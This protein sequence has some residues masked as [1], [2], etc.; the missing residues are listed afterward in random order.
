[1]EERD[2]LLESAYNKSTSRVRC[3]DDYKLLCWSTE[4][5]QE[6][7]SEVKRKRRAYQRAREQGTGD[8]KSDSY[9]EAKKSLQR[10]ISIAKKSSWMDLCD[11]LENLWRCLSDRQGSAERTQLTPNVN[12]YSELFS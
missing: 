1:M 10:A 4:E 3:G 5:I 11:S 8:R 7:L 2:R 12:R 6:E 9:R